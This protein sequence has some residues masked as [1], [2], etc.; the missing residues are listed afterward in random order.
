MRTDLFSYDFSYVSTI[1]ANNFSV[2]ELNTHKKKEFLAGIDE[3]KY[4]SLI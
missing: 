4:G 3:I 2:L 1:F